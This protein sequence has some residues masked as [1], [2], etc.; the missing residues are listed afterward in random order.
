[1]LILFYGE[2]SKIN[3]I[4]SFN[5]ILFLL[6]QFLSM[7]LSFGEI[8]FIVYS[9]S[10][11]KKENHFCE[12][13]F[14]NKVAKSSSIMIL[15]HFYWRIW[16]FTQ[17]NLLIIWH[18]LFMLRRIGLCQNFTRCSILLNS[19]W[20]SHKMGSAVLWSLVLTQ[21]NLKT[22]WYIQICS[23]ANIIINSYSTSGSDNEI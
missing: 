15:R 13:F 10:T 3:Q 19:A 8:T 7:C 12:E 20:I 21:Y 11:K 4:E 14:R 22:E 9:T 5:S 23:L 1:M 17:D 18:K 6:I 2:S 16:L